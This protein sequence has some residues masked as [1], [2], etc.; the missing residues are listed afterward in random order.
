MLRTVCES[1]VIILKTRRFSNRDYKKKKEINSTNNN[2]KKK[3]IRRIHYAEIRPDFSIHY[4]R[5][6]E[7]I[8]F[9][10]IMFRLVFE[11]VFSSHRCKRLRSGV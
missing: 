8:C 4:T 10:K 5:D 3:S 9:R 1:F 11:N 2:T 7:N 6:L